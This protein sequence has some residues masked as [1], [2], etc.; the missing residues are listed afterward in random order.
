MFPDEFNRVRRFK[1]KV[2]VVM[3]NEA[4]IR[5]FYQIG[6]NLNFFKIQGNSPKI[7]CQKDDYAALQSD[8][9][10]VGEDFRKVLNPKM[11]PKK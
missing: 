8:W 1:L 9:K 6:D 7:L 3:L 10:K 11:D 5:F 2:R 4:D